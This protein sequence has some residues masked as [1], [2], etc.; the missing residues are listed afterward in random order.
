LQWDTSRP[1]RTTI[2]TSRSDGSVRVVTYGHDG[3]KESETEITS[4]NDGR[5]THSETK[6]NVD[7]STTVVDIHYESDSATR[8]TTTTD[9]DGNKTTETVK[10]KQNDDGSTTTTTTTTDKDGTTTTKTE[11]TPPP[12]RNGEGS[13]PSDD[14]GEERPQRP[15]SYL[16]GQVPLVWD[17]LLQLA[18]RA[19][20]DP[21]E[22]IEGVPLVEAVRERLQGVVV[23]SHSGGGIGWGDAANE[24]PPTRP[25]F[26]ETVTAGAGGDGADDWGIL[27][28]N[29]FVAF[30]NAQSRLGHSAVLR[31]AHDI[32]RAD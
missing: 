6:D 25:D 17:L 23:E 13:M 7:G 24:G 14:G 12:K 10:V 19:G 26:D 5:D 16:P 2:T 20:G 27:H 8:T 15:L 22:E 21:G 1:L 31:L 29:A 4:S 9:R 28:P 30:G 32:F 18:A 3:Q 11:T